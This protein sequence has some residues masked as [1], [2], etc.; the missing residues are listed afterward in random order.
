MWT[1]LAIFFLQFADKSGSNVVCLSPMAQQMRVERGIE[2][3]SLDYAVSPIYLDSLGR[4][5]A[6]VLHTS[7]WM[8][9]ATV[10]AS[11]EVMHVIEKCGF[12][13]TIYLTRTDA[14]SFGKGS[15]SLRKREVIEYPK[16]QQILGDSRE[17]E[18]KEAKGGQ[19]AQ[20]NLLPLHQAGYKG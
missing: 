9:G 10:E 19:L 17:Q 3:D 13:D 2:I 15:V 20:L 7:R 1:L 18:G 4:L 8:N 14:S 12:V 11:D 16:N 6:K 5:G